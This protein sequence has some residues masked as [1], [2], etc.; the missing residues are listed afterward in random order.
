MHTHWLLVFRY[1]FKQ[2]WLKQLESVHLKKGED[3]TL[4]QQQVKRMIDY[5][6]QHTY[7]KVLTDD[8]YQ[9]LR[10]VAKSFPWVDG[11]RPKTTEGIRLKTTLSLR[12]KKRMNRF[13][14]INR[15]LYLTHRQSVLDSR[16]FQERKNAKP[17]LMFGRIM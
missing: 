8:E 16:H 1:R 5:L 14:I 17:P 15:V 13:I 6:S 10:P 3:N 2:V 7:Y 9:L 4:T 12:R 11:A